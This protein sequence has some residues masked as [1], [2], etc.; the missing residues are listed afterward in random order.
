MNTN[1]I[2]NWAEDERPREKLLHKGSEALTDAELLAILISSGTK[3]RS[4]LD[5][6][7]DILKQANNHLHDLGRLG[8]KEL[9]QTKGIGEARAIT[10]AAALELGRR[11]QVSAG[12]TRPMVK[13]SKD[14]ADI[15]IPLMRDLNHEVFYVMYLSPAGSVIRTENIG[16]GGLSS[17]VADL[18]IILKNALLNNA[19]RIIVAHNHPSGNLQPSKEDIAMTE[20]LK[21]AATFMDIKLLDH[22]IIGD[23]NYC[24]MADEGLI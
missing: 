6:A 12:R 24:S 11:R 18:R 19:S 5:L 15:L 23:N 17:T 2:K 20:K 4:A 9:Q 10:I 16:K 7:R 13:S 21:E 3:E 1:S 22:L 8:V 14:A